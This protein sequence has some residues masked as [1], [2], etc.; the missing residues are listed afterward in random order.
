M[1]DNPCTRY[2]YGLYK[3]V[4]SN[5]VASIII[6]DNRLI[7]TYELPYLDPVQRGLLPQPMVVHMRKEVIKALSPLV[8]FSWSLLLL[9]L[10]RF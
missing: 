6:D 1:L 4:P 9:P 2:L 10:K 8:W 7:Q 3:V 5:F